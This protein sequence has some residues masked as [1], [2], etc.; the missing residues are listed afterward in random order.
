MKIKKEYIRP[1]MEVL[2]PEV[3]PLMQNG[4]TTISVPKGS[5]TEIIPEDELSRKNDFTFTDDDW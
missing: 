3:G 1:I 5:G 2:D 4:V